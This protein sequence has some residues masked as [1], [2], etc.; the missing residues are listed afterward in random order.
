MFAVPCSYGELVDKV[1]ILSIKLSKSQ[2][3][4]QTNNIHLEYTKLV[5]MIIDKNEPIISQLYL[6]NQTLWNL[7]D[8]IRELSKNKDFSEEYIQCAEM[9]HKTNDQRYHLKK[10]LNNK[11]GSEIREEKIY[12]QTTKNWNKILNDMVKLF[13]T[14]PLKSYDELKSVMIDWKD[15]PTR[16]LII[17]YLNFLNMSSY[18]GKS[19]ELQGL[20]I[21]MIVNLVRSGYINDNI[22]A[23]YIQLG[24]QMLKY[25][26][27]QDA[28]PYLPYL[29]SATGP[30][31]VSPNNVGYFTD[32]DVDKTML[33]YTAGGLGDIIMFGRFLPEFCKRYSSNSIILFCCNP[34]I[35]I[36][37]NLN[38]KIWKLDNLTI[39]KFTVNTPSYDYHNNIGT[40]F[41]ALGYTQ[42]TLPHYTYLQQLEG[43]NI[44]LPTKPYLLFGWK[45]NEENSHELHNRRIPLKSL[46]ESIQT[47]NLELVTTQRD[48]TE[49]EQEL[50]KQYNVTVITKCDN[51]G[52]AFFDTLTLVKNA[53]VVVSSDT[54][55]LHLAGSTR[56]NDQTTIAMIVF[57]CE[58]RWVKNNSDVWY[59]NIKVIRQ[60]EFRNWNQAMV[61]LKNSLVD[62]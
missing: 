23:I 51:Q 36:F 16:L 55:L 62:L 2:N 42:E 40:L 35:W 22:S 4:T 11:Y 46:L 8:K 3:Q 28:R 41:S 31:G 44:P 57:G 5:P 38:E 54:A 7:E 34:L 53:T 61:E 60:S 29:Q 48:I 49:E 24:I 12:T 1:T 21:D 50:L 18:V 59:P 30:N 43:G 47:T 9:I 15:I 56:T 45:G 25:G 32:N 10:I 39:S 58:W 19:S 17:Y 26:R 33:L 37:K 27:Y 52:K 6:V 14:D 13:E 20:N